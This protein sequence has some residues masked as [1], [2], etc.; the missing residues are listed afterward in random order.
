[1]AR[2]QEP[3]TVN[4]AGS[5]PPS[6]HP[7]VEEFFSGRR[8]S[9]GVCAVVFGARQ[10]RRRCAWA[11]ED[12]ACRNLARGVGRHAKFCPVHARILARAARRERKRRYRGAR[13]PGETEMP[14]EG[15]TNPLLDAGIVRAEFVIPPSPVSTPSQGLGGATMG[16]SCS[17]LG[18]AAGRGSRAGHA[19]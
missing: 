2:K 8:S 6:H 12:G 17:V 15:I 16:V 14:S 4:R 5:Q 1:M 7:L 13:G 10:P 9:L 19:Q 3:V 18:A 11:D